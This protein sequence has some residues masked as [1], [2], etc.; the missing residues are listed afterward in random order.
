M[1]KVDCKGVAQTQAQRHKTQPF[2]VSSEYCFQVAPSNFLFQ[3]ESPLVQAVNAHQQECVQ[4]SLPQD[5]CRPHLKSWVL[6][7]PL[8]SS[9]GL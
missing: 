2:T 5:L 8:Y 4:A 7:P 6:S 1:S 9:Q 3:K